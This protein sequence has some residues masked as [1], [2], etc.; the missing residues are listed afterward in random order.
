MF[1]TRSG[2]WLIA[3]IAITG[4]LATIATIAFAPDKDL[5]YYNFAK[6][7]GY[8]ITVILPM[9]ALLSITSEWSQRS[10]RRSPA[11]PAGGAWSGRGVVVGHRGGR[12]HAVRFRGRPSNVVG[13]SIAG[14]PTVWDLS[15][16][17]A[18]D[19]A[20][21]PGL[22]LDRHHA[23]DAAPQL[24]GVWWHTSST[25]AHAQPVRPAGQAWYKDRP[26]VDLSCA[27][28]PVRRNADGRQWAHITT[29]VLSGSS[30][31]GSSGSAGDALRG[32]VTRSP[33]EACTHASGGASH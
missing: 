5:T 13:S 26:W 3:S 33:P 30:S 21:Q 19:R 7:V 27:D 1:D 8:P 14:T 24:A 4:L 2:F 25:S 18:L 6:A 16:G 9:V 10:G 11:S 23:G 32:E 17:H 22:P 20:R 15:L 12:F 31:R 29:T 28:L